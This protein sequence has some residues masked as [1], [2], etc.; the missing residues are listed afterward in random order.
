MAEDT[1]SELK[2]RLELI[3][4]MLAA[5][6]RQTES[7]GWTFLLWGIA[8]YVAIAVYQLTHAWWAWPVTMISAGVLT[9]L[10][11][12]RITRSKPGTTMGRVMCAIWISLGVS[13][14]V[15]LISLAQNH[16]LHAR[17]S[18]AIVCTLLGMANAI[19]GMTLKWTMQIACAVV[20]WLAAVVV[21]FSNEMQSFVVFLAAIF[22]CQ[23]VFGIYAMICDAKR[24]NAGNSHA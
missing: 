5:S 24:R 4:S 21:C 6:R 12:M 23:I 13:M 15:L 10:I 19:S 16:M 17:S 3:E 7:W 9:F 20:W 18:I 14:F 11:S 22:I 2:V 8:Y 1:N